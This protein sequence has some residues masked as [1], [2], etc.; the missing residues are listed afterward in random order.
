MGI[1]NEISQAYMI[2]VFSAT[3]TG[4]DSNNFGAIVQIIFS[5]VLKFKFPFRVHA[6]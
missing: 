5:N 3:R 4:N 6:Q 1:Q 2:T